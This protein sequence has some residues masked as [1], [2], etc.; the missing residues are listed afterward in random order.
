VVACRARGTLITAEHHDSL[1]HLKGIFAL[2][3]D[4]LAD[5]APHLN[6]PLSYPSLFAG[7]NT[8]FT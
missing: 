6:V 4:F 8:G 5:L 3:C 7:L 2:Y 1:R